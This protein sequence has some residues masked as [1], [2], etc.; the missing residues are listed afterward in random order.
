MNIS[1][2]VDNDSPREIETPA[3]AKAHPTPGPKIPGSYSSPVSRLVVF[4]KV[5][6]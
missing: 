4:S 3:A 6:I 2:A 1:N 5:S